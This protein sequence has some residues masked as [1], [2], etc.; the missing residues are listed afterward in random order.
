[1]TQTMVVTKSYMLLRCLDPLQPDERRLV[2]LFER[3]NV[4]HAKPLAGGD[5]DLV[6]RMDHHRIGRFV[7]IVP[8]G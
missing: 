5:V 7:E 8:M 6:T 3:D 4:D 2:L 1:M